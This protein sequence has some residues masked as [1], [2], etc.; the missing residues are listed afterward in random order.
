MF[1]NNI[2]S[3]E[4]NYRRDIIHLSE[5]GTKIFFA[6]IKSHIRKAK[7]LTGKVKTETSNNRKD[8]NQNNEMLKKFIEGFL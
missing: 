3:E 7:T 4:D 6:N 8:N 1:H 2:N 5:K